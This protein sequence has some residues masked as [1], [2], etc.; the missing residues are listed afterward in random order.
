MNTTQTIQTQ[1]NR[2]QCRCCGCN[3]F[4]RPGDGV[5]WLYK[6]RRFAAHG[7]TDCTRTLRN[8]ER[9][10]ERFASGGP[11]EDPSRPLERNLRGGSP[12]PLPAAEAVVVKPQPVAYG[13][14]P[15][16]YPAKCR[17]CGGTVGAGD[18]V[19]SAQRLASGSWA[20]RHADTDDCTTTPPSAPAP[21]GGPTTAPAAHP[22]AHLPVVD[23]GYYAVPCFHSDHRH[24]WDFIRVDKPV[25]GKWAGWTFA[26]RRSGDVWERL[27]RDDQATALRLIAGAPQAASL[28]Y[29]QEI[30]HCYV[31]NRALTTDESRASGIGP[32]CRKRKGQHFISNATDSQED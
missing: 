7:T 14:R 25:D 9:E 4:I 19:L 23:G 32:D 13:N 28:R 1:P 15:N 10:A 27:S 29:A 24:S 5:T 22:Q 26:K 17:E 6:G 11:T 12:K 31:C 2:F 3:T 21:T 8:H 18:G 30:G 20:V 16:A